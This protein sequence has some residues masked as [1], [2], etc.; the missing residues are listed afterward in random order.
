MASV[1]ALLRWWIA[2]SAFQKTLLVCVM[3]DL[4]AKN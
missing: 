3:A 1:D 2:S 4:R